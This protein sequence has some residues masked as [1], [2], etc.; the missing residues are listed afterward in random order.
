MRKWVTRNYMTHSLTYVESVEKGKS[1]KEEK[2]LD[3]L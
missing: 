1:V 3:S 2:I